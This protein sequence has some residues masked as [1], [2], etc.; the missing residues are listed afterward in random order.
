M[1]K[2]FALKSI[3]EDACIEEY[4]RTNKYYETHTQK[5]R[6]DTN[7]DLQ[8][9]SESL[10]IIKKMKENPRAYFNFQLKFED[11]SRVLL[12]HLY[13]RIERDRMIKTVSESPN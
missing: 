1:G 4:L 12:K 13:M 11:Y 10:K 6:N 9:N 7:P 2:S 8:K 5:Y 3:D